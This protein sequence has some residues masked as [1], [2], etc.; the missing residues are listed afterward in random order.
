MGNEPIRY[1]FIDKFGGFGFDFSKPSTS[2][3]F[4]LCSTIVKSE[5]LE[6]LSQKIVVIRN[7]I[8]SKSEMG[9]RNIGSD[10]RRTIILTNESFT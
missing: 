3:L 4:I 1:A 2:K 10:D 9:S 8:F 6:E 7:K 5:D